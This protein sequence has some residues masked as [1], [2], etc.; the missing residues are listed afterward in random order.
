MLK[1]VSEF[2]DDL[3]GHADSFVHYIL[4]SHECVNFLINK[5]IHVHLSV[6]HIHWSHCSGTCNHILIKIRSFDLLLLATTTVHVYR[7]LLLFVKLFD[8]SSLLWN[9]V[10]WIS[11]Y[12]YYAV[13]ILQNLMC[14]DCWGWRCSNSRLVR[15]SRPGK[16]PV[17]SRPRTSTQCTS[18]MSSTPLVTYPN[19]NRRYPP[20]SPSFP[21]KTP[22]CTWMSLGKVSH[23]QTLLTTDFHIHD[24]LF[25][26]EAFYL[27]DIKYQSPDAGKLFI[28][29]WNW[30]F[31][32]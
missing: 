9:I 1:S 24:Y 16:I 17:R 7:S 2:G 22:S 6:S 32:L 30:Q 23:Y 14:P 13:I 11:N 15:L 26:H 25:G 8:L 3:D 4:A 18:P 10:I 28:L 19:S 29:P 27:H 21:I 12:L 31:C 5:E 20:I